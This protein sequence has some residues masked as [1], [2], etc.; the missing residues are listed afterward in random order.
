MRKKDKREKKGT[1][2]FV[3]NKIG[4]LKERKKSRKTE[5]KFNDPKHQLIK[6]LAFFS[7][8]LENRKKKTKK[9]NKLQQK[10]TLQ[11]CKFF[12]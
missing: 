1:T 3:A 4:G 12:F 6:Q 2:K 9:E 7:V 8:I 10:I 5:T 11:A